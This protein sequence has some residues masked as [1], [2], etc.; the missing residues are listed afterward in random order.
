ML[1]GQRQ[2]TA[3]QGASVIIEITARAERQRITGQQLTLTVV[4]CVAGIN[5]Q[6]GLGFN[7]ATLVSQA[8]CLKRQIAVVTQLTRGIVEQ[9]VN[10]PFLGGVVEC[11]HASTLVIER[12]GPEAELPALNIAVAVI[13]PTTQGE[14]AFTTSGL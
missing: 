1:R 12:G 14:A 7:G 4:N 6:R 3:V 11:D 2:L 13:Q 8:A 5:N 9:T 10:P